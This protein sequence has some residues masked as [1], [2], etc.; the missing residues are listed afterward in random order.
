MA[1]AM[2]KTTKKNQEQ[3]QMHDPISIRPNRLHTAI[4][5]SSHISR[6]PL[7]R[8]APMGNFG[9]FREHASSM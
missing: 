2:K 3:E 5:S 1:M 4:L 9:P 7:F 6:F 8:W